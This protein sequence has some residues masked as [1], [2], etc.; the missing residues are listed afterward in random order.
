M[1]PFVKFRS[2]SMVAFRS[3]PAGADTSAPNSTISMSPC[4]WNSCCT[5]RFHLHHW[6]NGR[7]A[8]PMSAACRNSSITNSSCRRSCHACRC[9]SSAPA[10]GV[11]GQYQG[12]PPE[13]V[14]GVPCSKLSMSATSRV[15]CSACLAMSVPRMARIRG[16]LMAVMS[17][18]GRNA[19]FSLLRS[20]KVTAQCM[21][22]SGDW[23]LYF[24]ASSMSAGSKGGANGAF[25]GRPPALALVR[26]GAESPGWCT[27]WTSPARTRVNS[28][29]S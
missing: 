10:G 18:D 25:H 9:S 22:S 17:S 13:P 27:S 23:S 11:A 3:Y 20:S 6:V 8:L 7:V 28:M 1:K 12:M 29:F 2:A 16:L 24:E 21:F 5:S 26:K 14:P 4:V 15:R 19:F